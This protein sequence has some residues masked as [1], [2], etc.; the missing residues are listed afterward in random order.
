MHYRS[1]MGNSKTIQWN[2]TFKRMNGW[3]ERERRR[4]HIFSHMGW[5]AVLC[6]FSCWQADFRFSCSPSLY[7]R[8]SVSK[9]IPN[10]TTHDLH[11]LYTF[12]I[13]LQN[14]NHTLPLKISTAVILTECYRSIGKCFLLWIPPPDPHGPCVCVCCGVCGGGPPA[15]RRLTQ[16][17]R[18]DNAPKVPGK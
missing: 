12:M 7:E 17:H 9:E 13:I 3:K 14:S 4:L 11:I 18:T 2:P 16:C 1:D 5:S 8:L 6:F 15:R 10:K